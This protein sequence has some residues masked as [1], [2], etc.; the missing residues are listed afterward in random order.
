MNSDDN[1]V[2]P[3]QNFDDV[4]ATMP[5]VAAS[6]RKLIASEAAIVCDEIER[7]FGCGST[8]VWWTSMGPI[9]R[10]VDDGESALCTELFR[11]GVREMEEVLFVP[12]N[13]NGLPLPVYSCSGTLLDGVIRQCQFWEYY[14]Y[15][16]ERHILVASTDHNEFVVARA[17]NS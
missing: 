16:R 17:E 9:I 12:D 14:V 15:V 13:D 11:L 1:I 2:L 7:L 10:Q 8:R 6:F 4:L 3:E 5:C